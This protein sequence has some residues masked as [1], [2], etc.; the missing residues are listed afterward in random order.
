MTGKGEQLR[1]WYAVGCETMK[2]RDHLSSQEAACSPAI[3]RALV[4]DDVSSHLVAAG[5]AAS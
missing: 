4:E 2:R 5:G 1:Q 3:F